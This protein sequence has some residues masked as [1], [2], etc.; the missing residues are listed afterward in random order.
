M[1]WGRLGGLLLT[2]VA[3]DSDGPLGTSGPEF[4]IVDLGTVTG[5]AAQ[6]TDF[7]ESGQFV[8]SFN[9][10][11]FN[12][13][14]ALWDANGQ[15]VDIWSSLPKPWDTFGFA[16]NNRGQVVG[17]TQ[18]FDPISVEGFLWEAGA[19]TLLAAPDGRG[20][21]P[22]DINEAGAIV[23]VSRPES[24]EPHQAFLLSNGAYTD[25]GTLAGPTSTAW[26]L[27]ERQQIVGWSQG[28]DASD[29]AVLWSNG[30]LTDLRIP[31]E[32]SSQAQGLSNGEP[33]VIVG[34]SFDATGTQRAVAWTV[35]GSQ[36]RI[37]DLS[38][39][40]GSGESAALDVNDRGEIVGFRTDHRG[41][42]RPVLWRLE[43]ELVTALDLAANGNA[44]KI[45]EEGEIFGHTAV[46]VPGDFSR[47]SP[48]LWRRR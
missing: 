45:N 4:E 42:S 9:D 30:V 12:N 35:S 32:L 19:V 8:G 20:L 11:L 17:F 29:H 26:A 43:G 1:L 7:N 23:G 39:V 10:T 18:N 34:N 41:Y 37:I 5:P 14:A 28:E 31:G 25:L 38:A 46:A 6:V 3:C 47:S 48:T 27:N 2:L 13:Y 16:V 24:G 33:L 15:R 36:V 21:E 22:H 44:L 40:A